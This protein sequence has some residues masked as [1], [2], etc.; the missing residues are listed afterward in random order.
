MF[1]LK[2][3]DSGTYQCVAENIFGSVMSTMKLSI[4]NIDLHLFPISVSSTYVT[5]VS[6]ILVE[7]CS[8]T[9]LILYKI[10]NPNN[11]YSKNSTKV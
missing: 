2:P 11:F 9:F 5:L 10:H 8:Q 4:D 7:F 6:Q 1:H 3:R